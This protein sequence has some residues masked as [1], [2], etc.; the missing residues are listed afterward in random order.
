[1]DLRDALTQISEIRRQVARTEVFR[2]YRAV[3]VAFSGFLAIAVALFQAATMPD[4]A[5]NLEAYLAIWISAA[6]LSMVVMGIALFLYCW[7]YPSP[8]TR[9][10]TLLA[11][12]QFLPC[13]VA[14]GVLAFTLWHHAQQTLWLLPGLWAILFS[15]GIFASYRLLP[16]ATFWIAVYYLT[17][18]VFCLAW[19][20][21]EHAFSP[22]AMGGT[23][24]A[25]QLLSAAILYWTLE[26]PHAEE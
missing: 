16:Q 6:L 4:P 5:Q 26:R 9:T 3:P 13:I 14:G 11:V 15:L 12:S 18:G 20:Q 7:Q 23:F 1:M 21:G 17:A 25:G 19:A 24:G 2:G 10:T 22:W 8:L